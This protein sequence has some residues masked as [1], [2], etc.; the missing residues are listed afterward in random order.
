M[1]IALERLG[2]ALDDKLLIVSCD[3]LG[4]SQASN[5]GIYRALREGWATT[6]GLMVPAPWAREAASRYRG[7]DIGVHLAV[8]AEHELFRWGPVTQAPS[9]LSGEGGFPRSV[10]DVWEHADLDELRRECRAQI[11]R[12][13]YWG[14]DVTHLSS[15]LDALVL[16]PEFFD[17]ALELAVDHALPMRL[18]D[19]AEQAAGFPFRRLAS[20]EGIVLPDHVIPVPKNATH[21]TIDRILRDLRPGVTELVLRPA[22][23]TPEL[24]SITAHWHEDVTHLGLLTDDD[25]LMSLLDRAGVERIGYRAL[26]DAQRRPA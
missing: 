16:R 3:D 4:S 9:L 18:P 10:I 11:D 14:F 22:S 24:R 13:I 6:A 25:G 20:E 5:T 12:A 2:R 15:H 26:R 7:E 8:N 23:D 17:V 19:D 1:T 21:A